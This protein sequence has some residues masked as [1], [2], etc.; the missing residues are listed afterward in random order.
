[1][2]FSVSGCIFMRKSRCV[3]VVQLCEFFYLFPRVFSFLNIA[4]AGLWRRFGKLCNN[5][6]INLP[7]VAYQELKSITKLTCLRSKING[8]KDTCSGLFLNALPASVSR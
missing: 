5:K 7:T 1:M 3:S 4:A 6:L 8:Y 2:V